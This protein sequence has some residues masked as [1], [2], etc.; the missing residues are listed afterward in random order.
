MTA[1]GSGEGKVL[2]DPTSA[3]RDPRKWRRVAV[4]VA[5]VVAVLALARCG[6]DVVALGRTGAA[7]FDQTF[8]NG[9]F[10]ITVTGL[11][12]GVQELDVDAAAKA[13]GV[14]ACQPKNGQFIVVYA[15]AKRVGFGRASMPS[16]S[17]TLTDADGKTYTAAGPHPGAVGQ[18]FGQEQLPGTTHSGW[19]AF[20][21]PESVTMPKTLNVQS[22]PD[23]GTTN[24]P[25]L[26]RFG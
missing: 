22:D 18:G 9:S 16:M 19:F 17:S 4:L 21:V 12:Y 6:G 5:V 11:A 23:T 20:D 1:S 8:R 15:E 14:S 10:L 2:T 13:R 7:N 3:K 24:P 26:V 25:T